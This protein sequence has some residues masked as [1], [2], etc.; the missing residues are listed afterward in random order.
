MRIKKKIPILFVKTMVG[1]L[2]SNPGSV[3]VNPDC[4]D[5]HVSW[6]KSLKK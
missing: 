1:S 3:L 4:L 2:S 5:F 6:D